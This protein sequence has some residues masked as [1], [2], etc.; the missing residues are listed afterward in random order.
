MSGQPQD[1]GLAVHVARYHLARRDVDAALAA[2][3]ALAA[4]PLPDGLDRELLAALLSDISLACTRSRDLP[5][6]ADAAR[7]ARGI[8]DGPAAWRAVAALA[9]AQ[10]DHARALALWRQLIAR[11]PESAPAWLAL[12]RAAE[13]AGE[14]AAAHDAYVAAAIHDPSQATT[15]T[16]SEHIDRLRAA[17]VGVG[18]PIRIAMVGSSTLDYARHYVNVACAQ[19]GIA[20]DFYVG[21]YGQYAQELLNASSG[22]FGF[23]AD[24]VI[25]SVHGRALFPELYDDPFALPPDARRGA[26]GAAV[27]RLTALVESLTSRSRATVLLH[28]FATPQHS[29]A[30]VLD[31]RDEFGQSELFAH[32]NGNLARIVRERFLS[33]RLIDEDRVF[34]R[35]GKREMTDPRLW[36][37]ARIGLAHDALREATGEYMR[38]IKPLLGRNRKCLV[39]DLDNTLWGG[40]IG[41]DGPEGIALGHEAPGNAYRAFQE[42]IA[43][44]ARR[45][46]LLAINS[47]NNEQ[48]ALAVL[49]HHPEMLLRP[50]DFAAMRIN[51]LDKAANLRSIADELNI[52]L[53]SLVFMDDN[54]VECARVRAGLPQVLTVALPKDP[55]LFR[56]TLLDLT[57]FE[58]LQLTDEDRQRGAMYAQQRERRSLEAEQGSL[59][60]FLA[61]LDL[62]VDIAALADVD[63]PRVTQLIGKTN[64][65]NLTTVRHTE[66]AVRGF[67]ASRAHHVYTVRVRDRFGDHGLTGVAI[68]ATN[69]GAWTIETLLLSCRVLGCGVETALLSAIA[70][71]AAKSGATTLHGLFTPTARNDVA[72]PFYERHGFCRNGDR[73][74]AQLWSLGLDAV[75]SID[76]PAWVRRTS[77][78]ASTT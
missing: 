28:T 14:S 58:T 74:S 10:G 17:G 70:A 45:G 68:V 12:A 16:V 27:E 32:I 4:Q 1:A 71:A 65:F 55:A 24:I 3:E 48:E 38:V 7:L 49:E 64:Q 21:P 73:D 44:L 56:R 76:M 25:V 77:P 20:A 61:A 59:E 34:G 26:A 36:H 54:P 11:E 31:L 6:A 60:G 9:S 23:D 53:D 13:G 50:R 5:R 66:Q 57:D 30:G 67:A 78:P 37:M 75:T 62:E 41:E 22:L 43:A 52:G 8:D 35:T 15:L 42:A 63:V 33:V 2:V 51:W 69:D 39:L 29:P 18:Q 72:A 40:V 46:I 19:A 47:K